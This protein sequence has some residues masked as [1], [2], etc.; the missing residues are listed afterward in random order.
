[1]GATF[2]AAAAKPAYYAYGS[3]GNM[4]YENNSVY[5]DGQAAG[6][7]EQY[8]QQALALVAAAPAQ[9]NDAKWLPLGAFAFTREDVGDSQGM[10]ELAIN[11]QRVV[12]GTYYNE[13]TGVSRPP[14]GTLDQKS[15]RVAIGF[16]DGK[17]ADAALETGIYNLTQDEAPG[18]LHLGASEST[19]VLLVRLQPPAVKSS[20]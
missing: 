4:Y 5:V 9:A 3:G 2:A 11:K 10:I 1:M 16:A 18:L 14:K 6:T 12:A 17:N 15:Q 13:T 8:A 7:A 20:D 19:P